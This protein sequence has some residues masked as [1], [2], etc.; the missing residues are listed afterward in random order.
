MTSAPP[1]ASPALP[2]DDVL[3]DIA[4]AL[5]DGNRLVVSAPPGA[6]KTTRVPLR[7]LD[8]G[9]AKKG[10]I[11][12]VQPR[13]IAARAA[14]E[15]MAAT[16]GEKVGQ[17]VGLRTRMDVR[18]S[19]D[20]RIEVVTEGVFTRQILSDPAVEQVACVIFDEFHE[21][22]LDADEGIAFA[23]DTQEVLRPDLRILVMSATLPEGLT[24]TF[25]K[26][27]IVESDGRI[28][29]VETRYLGFD[30]KQRLEDQVASAIRKALSE[31]TGS[32]LAFL[33]G[34][35]EIRRT[36]ERLE[37]AP[38][39]VIFCP[40]YGALSPKE[41]SAAIAPPP[42]GV[43]KVVIAT[44]IAE[45]ALT[46]EGVRVVVDGGFA[47]LP[48]YDAAL[49][50]TRLETL[51]IARANADQRRGRAGRTQ[52]GVCYRLWREAEM[53][54][55]P[56]SP[57][58]E[59]ES[60]DLTNFRLDLAIWGANAP[61]A[62]S[63][64]TPPRAAAF[65]AATTEL[66]RLG[67]LDDEGALTPLGKKLNA[68]PVSPQLA[69]MILT[70]PPGEAAREA[71]MT[72][73]LLSERD[74]GGRSTD[75]TERLARLEKGDGQRERAMRKL[76]ERWAAS[77]SGPEDSQPSI[78]EML[79]AAMPSRIARARPNAP[80]QYLLAGGRGAFVDA[81]DPLCRHEWLVVADVIGGGANLRITLA[82]PLD[83]GAID[84]LGLIETSETARFDISSGTV[85]A[86]RRRSLGA[87]T[88][89]DAPLPTP[90]PAAVR[91][92]IIDAVREHG[93]SVLANADVLETLIN[94][95][96][97]LRLT[98]GDPWP[99]DFRT[100][101]LDHLEDWLPDLPPGA[102]KPAIPPQALRQAAASTLDWELQRDLDTLAP[103]HWT[104]PAG[105]P[106]PIDYAT[107]DAP[108]VACKIQQV[109]GLTQH[110]AI[111][112][113]RLPLTLAL[114]S[115]ATRPIAITRDIASFWTGGYVDVRKD[116]KARYPK[117]LWPEHPENEA[118]AVRTIRPRP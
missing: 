55:F 42:D 61:D 104:T 46:I 87:I 97:C 58:P 95:I 83:P 7:F 101:L 107:P 19:N 5:E 114:L 65:A 28:H 108:S 116:M 84:R 26:A 14:A 35:A 82:A 10:R 49:G 56:A 33:P 106:A 53:G 11:T 15:R 57:P 3:E 52:P 16:L 31:E 48:R 102:S 77:A 41:Q 71:A 24:D 78:S 94:R 40:L 29:P 12:L 73:A 59:I 85:R 117:H 34:A 6:G 43:R 88:L 1:P 70:A 86:R 32:I 110:P 23:L 96:A 30:A 51:R 20:T 100:H 74:L 2:I 90:P 38:P 36:Q 13:R 60:A 69:M 18:V 115:P 47:R 79:A 72:S 66:Q 98:L 109:F 9:W 50:A 8:S 75:L 22:S 89:E 118:P 37:P 80:G 27:P 99:Q 44:D 113:T 103:T 111:A 64:P 67:A 81:S 17:T 105:A 92:A 76:A 45:S 68:L 39:G 54:G 112:G 63:W 62:L 91:T 4:A 25:F 93:L 21:R